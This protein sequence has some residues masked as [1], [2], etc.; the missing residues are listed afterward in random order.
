MAEEVDFLNVKITSLDLSLHCVSPHVM[1]PTMQK[2]QEI[3]TS[4]I[5]MGIRGQTVSQPL[6]VLEFS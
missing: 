1:E 2:S 3:P 4:G 6:E 5:A